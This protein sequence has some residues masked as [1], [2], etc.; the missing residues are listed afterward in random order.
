LPFVSLTVACSTV[1]TG[2]GTAGALP[3]GLLSQVPD[4]YQKVTRWDVAGLLRAEGLEEAP[5]D[6]REQ[7]EW[8]ER[9]GIFMDDVSELVRA[10]DDRD[11]TLILLAGQFDW[12][13]IID[14][15]DDAGFRDSTYRDVEVWARQG[16]V[17]LG[18][19]EERNQVVLST[20]GVAVVR[21]AIRAL[22]R[23]SGFLLEEGNSDMGRAVGRVPQG[24][25]MIVEEGC[26]SVDASGCRAMAYSASLGEDKLT[27]TIDWVLLFRRESTARSAMRDVE[28]YFDNEMPREV[29]VEDVGQEE[30]FV[31]VRGSID[32]EDFSLLTRAATA[33]PTPTPTSSQI[34][35]HDRPTSRIEVSK[36]ERIGQLVHAEEIVTIDDSGAQFALSSD[37]QYLAVGKENSILVYNLWVENPVSFSFDTGG[38]AQTSAV[39]SNDGQ[40]VFIGN[41][42]GELWQF[43]LAGS[44]KERFIV[45]SG[46]QLDELVLSPDNRYLGWYDRGKK[47][48]GLF[49]LQNKEAI[50]SWENIGFFGAIWI[51]FSSNGK[52]FLFPENIPGDGFQFDA[53]NIWDIE[54]GGSAANLGLYVQNASSGYAI[55]GDQIFYGTR[56]ID[57]EQIRIWDAITREDTV[58]DPDPRYT[59]FIDLFASPSGRYI[60]EGDREKKGIR[61][62]D[63]EQ[64]DVRNARI[65]GGTGTIFVGWDTMPNFLFATDGIWDVGGEHLGAISAIE[66]RRLKKIEVS[67]DGYHLVANWWSF[68]GRG[69]RVEHH[70]S[71]LRVPS[72]DHSGPVTPAATQ[73]PVVTIAVPTPT[74]APRVII[75][76][77][78]PIPSTRV[79]TADPTPTPPVPPASGRIVFVST[80]DG[81]NEIYVIEA[82]GS[83]QTRLT[84]NHRLDSMPV[85]SPDGSKIAFVR[86]ENNL[87]QIYV[88]ESD[89]S[90]QTKISRSTGNHQYPAWSPDGKKIAFSSD[91]QIHVT[92]SDGS[93]Q[94]PRCNNESLLGGTCKIELP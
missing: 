58:F 33:R 9:Y 48:V 72:G 74:P 30:E 39:F 69:N 27:L 50:A 45:T 42:K 41:D 60:A 3:T 21:D 86:V 36:E 65:L 26:S 54:K 43:Y 2:G 92:A 59:H 47:E 68:Q 35:R 52:Y 51:D 81:N 8:T 19:L 76:T 20:S 53:L 4:G 67:N 7:W 83:K 78:P 79:P 44:T 56:E 77:A 73:P 32:E 89:G 40:K 62:Y 91:N 11:D 90:K 46:G 49:D 87:S 80:R 64:N 14:D 61:I 66:G 22:D 18:L 16:K 25:H 38:G 37:S 28:E 34:I 15:L 94:T 75:P 24:L 6:F 71:L 55:I 70:T 23:G 10:T 63:L 12:D 5:D 82:D 17:V 13:D 85:W 1:D 84:H 29:D 57:G 88:M 31:L 93:N